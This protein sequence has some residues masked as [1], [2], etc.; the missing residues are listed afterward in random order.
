MNKYTG[1]CDLC[2]PYNSSTK[3][4]KEILKELIELGYKNVAVEQIFDHINHSGDKRNDPIPV[5]VDLSAINKEL[6]GRL[7]LLNR[8]TIIYAE[9][10]VTL[11]TN[12]SA[13]LRGYNLISV[14]PT[15]EDAFQ[16]A[17]QTMHCD[18]ISYNSDTIRGKM[19]RKYYFLAISRNIMFEIKYAPAIVDSSERKNIINRAHR[20]HSYGKSKNVII[21]SEAR[22][23]FQVRGPYDIANL[24]LI[25]GLSEEQSKNAILAMPRKILI[26]AEARRHGKAGLVISYRQNA[27][28]SDDYSDSELD[29]EISDSVEEE[30]EQESGD[31]EMCDDEVEEPPQK[32]AKHDKCSS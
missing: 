9:A 26:A 24:G 15:T 8:L 32:M 10:S 27:V 6:K 20:Y 29:E 30:E 13:N 21:T 11:V 4:L 2:V 5:P 3:D 7:R 28:D 22:N 16:H 18:V 31:E 14:I 12:R 19:S 17:C 25:F 1:F 23:R